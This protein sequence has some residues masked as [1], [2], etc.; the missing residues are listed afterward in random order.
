MK[1]LAILFVVFV[2]LFYSTEAMK[3]KRGLHLHLGYSGGYSSPAVVHHHVPSVTHIVATPEIH[4]HHIHRAPTV[5]HV[6]H[7]YY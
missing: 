1:L 6:H 7:S 4:H 3:E 5:H 2:A